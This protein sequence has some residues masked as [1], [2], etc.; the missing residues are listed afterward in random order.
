MSDMNV[1]RALYV[2]DDDATREALHRFLKSK[3]GKLVSAA[4]GEEGLVRFE[5]FRPNLL[6]VDLMMPGMSGLEMIGEIRKN[7]KDCHILITT[8]VKEL[9]T[10]LEAVDLGIDHYIVKPIDTDDL[11]AK[12]EGIAR[13]IMS[14]EGKTGKVNLAA[15]SGSGQMEDGIR[16]EFLKLLKACSG[17]GPRDIKVLLF[18]NNVEITLFDATTALEKTVAQNHRNLSLTEQFRRVFYGEI[19]PMVT[20]C[21]EQ[22]TGYKAEVTSIEVDGLKRV[23]KIVL[24][25]F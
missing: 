1:L 20:E 14:G 17:K 7:H 21:V 6:I 4:T 24:T 10:V 18:E 25:V 16:K 15:L 2:E 11:L 5:E 23:D 12:M 19:S 3:V 9:D 22:I 13:T 8:S